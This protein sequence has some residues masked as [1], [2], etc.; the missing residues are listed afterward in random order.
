MID[1]SSFL[2]VPS[3]L[4]DFKAVSWSSLWQNIGFSRIPRFEMGLNRCK[5]ALISLHLRIDGV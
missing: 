5:S 3:A 1:Y 2:C 4:R